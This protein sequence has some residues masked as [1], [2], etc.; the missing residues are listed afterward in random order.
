MALATGYTIFVYRNFAGKIRS[1]E[2]EEG[3][4]Y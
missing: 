1:T 3:E 2:T 4:G